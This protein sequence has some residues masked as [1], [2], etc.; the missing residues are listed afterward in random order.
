MKEI[1]VIKVMNEAMI[2]MQKEKNANYEK[3]LQIEKYLEDEAIFFKIAKE[4]AYKILENVGVKKETIEEVYK[5]LTTEKEF[6]ELVN[7]GKINAK[8]DKLIV[9]YENHRKRRFI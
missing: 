5:K 7:K 2:E 1:E 4:K 8:D 9:K 6:Y 3:N